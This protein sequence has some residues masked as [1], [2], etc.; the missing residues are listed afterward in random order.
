MPDQPVMSMPPKECEDNIEM[1]ILAVSPRAYLFQFFS[2]SEG[3]LNE[4]WVAKSLMSPE[5]IK[6]CDDALQNEDHP[7]VEQID[8][9]LWL[10]KD[11]EWFEP[12]CELY[13]IE[14]G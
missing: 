6:F 8:I 11:Q 5:D 10:L 4:L 7:I 2:Y 9:P 3:S 12:L 13:E 1:M 14:V